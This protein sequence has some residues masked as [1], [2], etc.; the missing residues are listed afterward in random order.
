MINIYTIEELHI[1]REQL[2]AEWLSL[3]EEQ[4]AIKC[5]ILLLDSAI[6]KLKNHTTP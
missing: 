4:E 2:M 1:R 5:N 3:E 6:V